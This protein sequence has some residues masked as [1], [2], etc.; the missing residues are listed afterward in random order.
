[1]LKSNDYK[2]VGIEDNDIDLFESQYVVPEGMLYNSY[3]LFDEKI[4]I[5]D[6]VDKRKT[7]EWLGKVKEAL[8]GKTPDYL[9]IHHLEPDHSAGILQLHELYPDMKL[10][11]NAKTF[12]ML[13]QFFNEDLSSLYVTVKEGESITFGK[14]TLTFYMAPMVHWP[15]VMVSYDNEEKILFAAD[16]FGKFGVDQT[17]YDWACEARR[18]YFNIV[19]KYGAQV[20][21]LLKKAANLDIKAIVA[22][23]GPVLDE[24]LDYYIGLYD[25]WSKY[26]PEDKGILIACASIHGNTMKAAEYLEEKLNEKG[27]Q[28]VVLSDVTREDITE[29]IED[30]F[31][32]DRMVLM[33]SSY[34]AGLFPPMEELLHH[35]AA[36]TYR[37]R[38]VA[39]VENGSWAPS[40]HRCMTAI[41]EKY[42]DVEIVGEKITIKTTM[43]EE[44][45]KELDALADVLVNA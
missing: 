30:A 7:D 31:R 21:A 29:V 44:N 36:K 24:N 22:L 10:I 6:T 41:V 17:T 3:V 34:D 18:Y 1:M 14:H 32:Y 5:F 39:I 38:K 19:G 28:K 12:S 13:P 33:A 25:T 4:V 35:L 26:E 40:A 9:I 23:H 27:A 43:S 42:K 2:Y 45:K 8:D 15:E 20:Q 16:G 11:G 37:N